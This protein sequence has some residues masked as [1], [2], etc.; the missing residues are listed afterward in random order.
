MM[1]WWWFFSLLFGL[2]GHVWTWDGMG[3]DTEGI[4]KE[5][6]WLAFYDFTMWNI[7]TLLFTYPDCSPFHFSL[8]MRSVSKREKAMK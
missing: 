5:G 2:A 1:V 3:W 6:S 4:G 7:M 8:L